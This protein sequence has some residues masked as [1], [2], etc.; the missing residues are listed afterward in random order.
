MLRALAYPADTAVVPL[1]QEGEQKQ[2]QTKQYL[3][4]LY[5]KKVVVP[6]FDESWYL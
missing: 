2:Q 4:S 3:A 1:A 6:E 5:I